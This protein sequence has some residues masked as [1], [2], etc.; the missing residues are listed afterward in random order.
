M[1]RAPLLQTVSLLYRIQGEL[2]SESMLQ[3]KV[4]VLEYD[5]CT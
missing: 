2:M 1:R 5:Q 4:S 3:L